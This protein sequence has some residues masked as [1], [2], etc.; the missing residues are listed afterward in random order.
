MPV[1]PMQDHQEHRTKEQALRH[2]SPLAGLE[3]FAAVVESDPTS[4][5]IVE[6]IVDLNGLV[7]QA[8]GLDLDGKQSSPEVA[9]MVTKLLSRAEML[10]SPEAL[11]A[12]RSEADGLRW[13]A[14]R[15]WSRQRQATSLTRKMTTSSCFT[16]SRLRMSTCPLQLALQLRLKLIPADEDPKRS[17]CPLGS[18]GRDG[19]KSDPNRFHFT[20]VQYSLGLISLKLSAYDELLV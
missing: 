9:A 18:G 16:R 11:A 7:S 5:R 4:K 12:L 13:Y 20:M 15:E 2:V 1:I 17:S 3:D 19:G 14:S 6:E 8:C 10:A